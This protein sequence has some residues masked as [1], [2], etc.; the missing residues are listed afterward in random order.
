MLLS[1]AKISCLCF[2]VITEVKFIVIFNR[3]SINYLEIIDYSKFDYEIKKSINRNNLI[4][5]MSIIQNGW[6]N[7]KWINRFIEKSV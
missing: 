2:F 7:Q 3:K 4:I 6:V 1:V 5:I